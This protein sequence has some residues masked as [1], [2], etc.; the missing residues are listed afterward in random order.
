MMQLRLGCLIDDLAVR[1]QISNALASSIF[2]TWL[3]FMSKE[4][5]WLITWPDRNIITRNLPAMF[6]KYYPKC[7]TIIDCSELFIETP[8]SLDVA[9]MCWS[10]Y[11]HHSTVKYL[12]GITP[13]GTAP[14]I[15]DC[16]G[17]RASD[18][19]IVNDSGCLKDLRPGDHVMADRGFKIHDTLAFYQSTLAIPPSK[20][21]NL[22]MTAEDVKNTSRIANVRIYVEQAIKRMKETRIIK[23]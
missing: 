13:N 4:L 8:T 3:K 11:K 21:N 1:F 9:A 19:F 23:K 20:Q 6:R 10:N 16:Y 14:Y 22:Q 17:G 18:Q 7:C 15:S 12:V 5:R 2:S